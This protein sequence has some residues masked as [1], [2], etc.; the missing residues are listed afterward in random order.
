[1]NNEMNDNLMLMFFDTINQLTE[2]DIDVLTLYNRNSLEDIETT[3][4]YDKYNLTEEQTAVIKDKLERLGLLYSK[5]DEQRDHNIDA[6]ADYLNKVDKEQKKNKSKEVRL[7][8]IK[9]PNRST[10]HAI[11]SL[12]RD[13]LKVIKAQ[14]I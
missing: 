4:L 12:G 14:E 13:Y 5:N 2:F 10:S 6:I 7:P 11:T 9:R 1:M 8:N 3:D